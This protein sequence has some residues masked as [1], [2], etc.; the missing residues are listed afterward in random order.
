MAARLGA[1]LDSW[2]SGA[3]PSRAGYLEAAD[4]LLAWRTAHGGGGLWRV[5]PLLATATLDDAWG[6]GLV[7]IH[8][9]AEAVGMRLLPLGACR[10]SEEILAACRRERPAF[11]GLTVLWAEA[12]DA[13]AAIVHDLPAQTRLIAGGP[14]FVADPDLAG[15]AGVHFVARHGAA[16]LEH[17][18]VFAS[19]E[20]NGCAPA[21]GR[22][23][24]R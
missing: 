4:A 21:C 7:V 19:Q 12:E 22:H 5:A 13:L 14:A 16:F 23:L 1:L 18:L 17:I 9:L 8:R 3:S 6:Q 2:R 15:R 20:E 10:S 24:S 11:L